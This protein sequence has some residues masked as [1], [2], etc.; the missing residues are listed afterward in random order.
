LTNP[1]RYIKVA[2]ALVAIALAGCGDPKLTPLGQHSVILAFGDSLTAG[3]GTSVD[4]AYPAVLAELSGRKVI[5]AGISG[6]TTAEGLE[7]LPAVLQGSTPDLLILMHGGNDIL[8][9]LG[10]AAAKANLRAMIE[11]ATGRGM[12]VVLIGV[13]E[14]KLLSSSAPYYQELADEYDLVFEKGM[15]SS[16]LKKPSLK[17]DSVHFNA[18]GYREI[19]S[20]VY[21]LLKEHGAF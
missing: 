2:I 20:R 18:A 9:N 6:E 14:K 8:R 16:L 10:A 12:Q 21:K 11:L 1:L 3:K 5:N 17:S 19:A 7:R 15:V 4:F 13:P